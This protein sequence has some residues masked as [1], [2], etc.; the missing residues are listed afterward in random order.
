MFSS[1]KHRNNKQKYYLFNYLSLII[2]NIFF[3]IK[4][5]HKLSK[6]EKY[7]KKYTRD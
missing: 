7:D 6:L 3:R 2:P 4:L 1:L 5:K